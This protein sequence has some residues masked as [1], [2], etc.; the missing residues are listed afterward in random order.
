[1]TSIGVNAWADGRCACGGIS[2][3]A[4]HA[5]ANR[6]QPPVQVRGHASLEMLLVA[7]PAYLVTA[8]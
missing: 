5:R 7:E 2:I 6:H 1:M 8:R 4:A 3:A